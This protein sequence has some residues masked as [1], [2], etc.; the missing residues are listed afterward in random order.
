MIGV[1]WLPVS[2]RGVVSALKGVI[3]GPICARPRRKLRH[4]KIQPL[5]TVYL[6]VECL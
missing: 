1:F 4:S 5:K 3:T 6:E 2:P